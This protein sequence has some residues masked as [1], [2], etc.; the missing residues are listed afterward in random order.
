MSLFSQKESLEMAQTHKHQE[1]EVR[2]LVRV[3]QEISTAKDDR[4]VERILTHIDA[5][6]FATHPCMVYQATFIEVPVEYG[7]ELPLTLQNAC[8]RTGVSV[9]LVQRF[10]LK[11]SPKEALP[12]GLH[13]IGLINLGRDMSFEA[14]NAGLRR[15]RHRFASP[16]HL[17]AFLNIA[18]S[19]IGTQEILIFDTLPPRKGRKHS[20]HVVY[21]LKREKESLILRIRFP[22]F[23]RKRKTNLLTTSRFVLVIPA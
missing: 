7:P 21:V 3:S 4:R 22:D 20:L 16:A 12:I 23:W 9:N 6:P 11:F 13:T 14:F 1:A 2:A 18:S 10:L 15:S 8:I 19:L 17:A 5:L